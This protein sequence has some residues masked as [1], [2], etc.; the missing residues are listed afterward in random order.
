MEIGGLSLHFYSAHQG[1]R[2]QATD[3]LP[4]LL[5]E[6]TSAPPS[7]ALRCHLLKAERH[8]LSTSKSPDVSPFGAATFFLMEFLTWCVVFF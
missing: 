7:L 4:G 3:L 2:S 8:V 1:S 6:T 5:E